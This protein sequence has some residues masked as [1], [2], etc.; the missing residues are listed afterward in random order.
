MDTG[1]YYNYRLNDSQ[2]ISFTINVNNVFDAEYLAESG[3]NYFPGDRG[4]STTYK[5]INTS[6]KAFFGF[7]R[8]W[9]ASMRYRF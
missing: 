5:G 6:N 8:T 1:A 7:G 4:N 3:S 2:T 9:N